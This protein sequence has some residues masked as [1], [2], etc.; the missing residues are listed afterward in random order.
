M[1]KEKEP[2]I[3]AVEEKTEEIIETKPVVDVD[4]FIA[5]KLKALNE[6]ENKAKARSLGERVLKNRR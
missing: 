2:K 1:A 3:E 6:M 4:K 5:R